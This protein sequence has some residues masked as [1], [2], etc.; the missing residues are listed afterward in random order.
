[1]LRHSLRLLTLVAVVSAIPVAAHHTD[2]PEP[3]G[4]SPGPLARPAAVQGRIEAIV[5][6]NRLTGASQ[7][8]PILAASDGQR[9]LM[10]GAGSAGLLAGDAVAIAGKLDGRALYPDT[11]A[12][13]AGA[14][15]SAK[16]A[17]AP[18]TVAGTLRLG[19][20]DNFDGSPSDFF[21]AV[22]TDD[23]RHVR[24]D[25]AT[26]L[27]GLSNGMH[28]AVSG[29]PGAA[30]T[31]RAERIVILAAAT[32]KAAPQISAKAAVATS[33]IVL[34]IKFPTNAAAPFAYGADPFT[35]A[36]LSGAVFGPTANNVNAY[37]NEVSYGQQTLSGIVADNGAGGFLQASVPA[38][39]NCDIAAIAT[40]A[41]N[42]ATARGYDLTKY[43]GRLYVFNNVGGCG[44]SGLAYVS[45]ARAYSNNSSNL[46]VIAH[47]LGHNF[48]LAH[49]ASVDCAANVIGGTCT[50]SEYG[51]P[52][53]VMG[54]QRA[55]HFS[56][57]QKALLNWLPAGGVATHAGGTQTY[58]LSPLES[59]GGTTYAVKVQAA[60][61]RTYWLEYRQPIGF[62]SAL[63][64]FPNNGAQV[65]VATPFESL[66][67]GCFDDTEFL[68]FTPAT[69]AFTDGTLPAGQSFTDST[70]GITFNVLAATPTALTVQIASGS[71]AVTTT[72]LSAAP[73]PSVTGGS[74]LLT[75]TVSSSSIPSGTVAFSD[76]AATLAG[77]AA[78]ALSGSG[79]ATCSTTLSAATSPHLLKAAY[80][81]GA[82]FAASSGTVTQVVNKAATVTAISAHTPNPV[83]V[84][85]AIAVTAGVTVTAPGSGT[86]TGTLTVSDG[87]ASCLITLPAATCNL[88]LITAGTKSLTASFSGDANFAASTSTS[89]AHT[90]NAVVTSG[91]FAIV[92]G[93]AQTARVG[94][95]FAAPLKVRVLDAAS[96]PVVGST[97][98]WTTPIVGADANLNTTTTTTD[99]QGYAQ[100]TAT[101]TGISGAYTV[102]ASNGGRNVTFTL[103]NALTSSA[104]LPCASSTATVQDLIE[105]DYLGLLQRPSDAGGKA[106][107]ASEA[108]RMCPLGIDA[109]QAFLVIGNV[110]LNS[111]EYASLGRSNAQFVT[112][113]YVAF[114]NRMPDSGGLTY[115]T[116]QLGSGMP[117][118]VV[119][120]AFLFAPEFNAAMQAVF[121]TSVSRSEV[122][123]IVDLYG[124]LF[125]RLPDSAGFGYWQTQFR[126]A[127]CTS[128]AAVAQRVDD[129]TK[130]FLN[131]TEYVGRG[132]SNSEY[133]QDLYYS[134][135]RRGG[136][137]A[138]FNSW[139]SQLNTGMTRENLRQQ[140]LASPE[141]QGRIAQIVAETCLP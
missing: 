40:A 131:T 115:W 30:G 68:D 35:P 29:T 28:V 56:A 54:N 80:A 136:D 91:S 52:F 82:G 101:A 65:R 117:R 120:N 114:L 45:W 121:G 122:S 36:S 11:I 119:L 94:S 2:V 100:V 128:A 83:N 31:L 102:I 141:M 8:F 13:T 51:D 42:A 64:G 98:A 77:C 108:A 134:F 3:L 33:Y 18:T 70:Y 123:T 92:S 63:S 23:G 25:L 53:D 88:T 21:Y 5:V 27:S 71:G 10:S 132:R 118:N 127:Q 62:D 59:A 46:L 86:P 72:T 74:V 43:T 49:A 130:Q 47:E 15:V 48:G 39:A 69:T 6:E 87:T 85:S 81:G 112:D 41:E 126:Q 16:A 104:S 107:W 34:P 12:F 44:W 57:A 113:I 20:A 9:Y 55:M 38:P 58:T 22:V 61:N 135:L 76:G 14:T 133:V 111:S 60:A 124:G 125:R 90:V 109:K 4:T 26:L 106:Y 138:G 116:G 67:S 79:S 17:P 105:Q 99:A 137:L 7:S 103:T 32:P 84:G 96:N 73:N 93:N 78:V 89:V 75:A 66:C 140:F 19:H 95:A 129:I 139:V 110:F 37:Y 1:M 50:S 24:V 97:V